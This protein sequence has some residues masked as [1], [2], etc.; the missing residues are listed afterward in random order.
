MDRLEP[1]VDADENDGDD[2]AKVISFFVTLNPPISS[3]ASLTKN[4]VTELVSLAISSE[5]EIKPDEHR[6]WHDDLVRFRS[7]LLEKLS[8]D[9]IKAQSCSM[10]HIERPATF[11]HPESPSGKAMVY[12]MAI[13]WQAKEKH[14]AATKTKEFGDTIEPIQEKMLTPLK[15]LEMR[16]VSFKKV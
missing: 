10:G 1:F 3:T 12:F 6:K 5:L 4:P 16:H 8:P 9:D 7:S 13:G 2:G 15:G 14:I 11:D